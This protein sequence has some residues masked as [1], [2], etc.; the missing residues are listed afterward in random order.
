MGVGS[1]VDLEMQW[2]GSFVRAVVFVA[3]DRKVSCRIAA[4]DAMALSLYISIK[5]LPVANALLQCSLCA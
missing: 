2:I 3:M 1:G 4:S 5:I